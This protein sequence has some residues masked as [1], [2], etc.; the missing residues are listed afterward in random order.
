MDGGVFLR[1]A[2]S[3]ESVGVVCEDSASFA[4]LNQCSFGCVSDGCSSGVESSLS[5]RAFARASASF[6]KKQ[7]LLFG[8]ELVSKSWRAALNACELCGIDAEQSPATLLILQMSA[9]DK[10]SSLLTRSQAPELSL[11]FEPSPNN[12]A[13]T[14]Y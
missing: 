8:E 14:L 4:S 1:A 10:D 6:W 7:V 9:I 5:S 13:S 12:N 11:G 3:H 2:R